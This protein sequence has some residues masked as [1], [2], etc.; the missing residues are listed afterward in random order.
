[1]SYPTYIICIQ[2]LMSYSHLLD[3]QLLILLSFIIKVIS[4]YRLD[5]ASKKKLSLMNKAYFYF[6]VACLYSA[7]IYSPNEIMNIMKENQFSI[8]DLL[9]VTELVYKY[10]KG[11]TTNLGKIYVLGLCSLINSL[12][13]T[14]YIPEAI[15]LVTNV[16]QLNNKKELKALNKTVKNPFDIQFHNNNDDDTEIKEENKKIENYTT[17]EINEY[18]EMMYFIRECAHLYVDE[19]D[20]YVSYSNMIKDVLLIKEYHEYMSA[21]DPIIKTNIKNYINSSRVPIIINGR[22]NYIG[23][24]I[25][26]LKRSST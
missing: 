23:R 20:E 10:R 17:E 21:L 24:K 6:S 14:N 11:I 2:V 7:I 19:K 18:E 1:M 22:K 5:I 9:A 13:K 8:E 26:T 12:S 25:V 15:N 16:L 3:D 4:K